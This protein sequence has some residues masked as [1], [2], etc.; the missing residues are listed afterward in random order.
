MHGKRTWAFMLYYR[1]SA[2]VIAE[3]LVH[4]MHDKIKCL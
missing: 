1:T 3:E 2:S 4:C